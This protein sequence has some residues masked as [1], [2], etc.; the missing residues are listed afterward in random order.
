MSGL[1]DVLMVKNVVSLIVGLISSLV[2]G[3]SV[4]ICCIVE[5]VSAIVVC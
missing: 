5:E 3:L 4:D 1:I 2:D